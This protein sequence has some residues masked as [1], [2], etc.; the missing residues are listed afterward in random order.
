MKATSATIG[1]QIMNHPPNSPNLALSAIHLFGPMKMHLGGQKFQTDEELKHHV[2]K[3][4]YSQDKTFH[5]PG[6]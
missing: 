2:L 3:W 1:W 4:L 5:A 6:S